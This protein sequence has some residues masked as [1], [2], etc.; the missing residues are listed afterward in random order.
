MPFF[1]FQESFLC[2]LQYWWKMI[3]IIR[4]WHEC[5]ILMI[6]SIFEIWWKMSKS[7]N[8][9]HFWKSKSRKPL[10]R[11]NIEYSWNHQYSIFMKSSI[12]NIHD[13]MNTQYWWTREYSILN[14]LSISVHEENLFSP[15]SFGLSETWARILIQ[16]TLPKM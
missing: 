16:Q 8:I 13:F 5:W 4:C 2:P 11:I 9:Q 1:G 6:L 14:S 12:F 10:T 15:M 3:R 7:I